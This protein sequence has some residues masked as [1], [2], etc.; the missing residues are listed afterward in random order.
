M[1]AVSEK[2]HRNWSTGLGEIV[3]LKIKK[4]T[5]KFC[6]FWILKAFFSGQECCTKPQI[7]LEFLKYFQIKL[8]VY[9]EENDFKI[10]LIKL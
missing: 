1:S 10:F 2:H 4:E 9:N 7:V 3:L 5:L 6:D 8:C